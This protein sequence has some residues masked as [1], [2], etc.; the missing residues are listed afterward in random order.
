MPAAHQ[1][2]SPRRR[3]RQ[4]RRRP[5]PGLAA[6][7]LV[8]AAIAATLLARGGS[9]G[10]PATRTASARPKPKPL[11]LP[12]PIPGYLL[13]ADRG[14]NRILLV[15][16]RK[17]ILWRYPAPGHRPSYPF[18]FDDD[19]FFGP[20][21]RKIIS[22]QEDQQ[23]IQIVSFPAGRVLW[24]YGQPN[25][26]G[27]AAGYLN[28]PDDAYLLPHGVVTVAD[29]YNCRILY[30][31]RTKRIIRQLG[32]AGVCRHDPPHTL[33]AVNGGT[34]LPGGGILV[35]EI[36]GSW[37]DAFN[38]RGRLLWS[39][40]APVSY[41]SDPQ[42][43]GHGK[44]MLADYARPGHVLILTRTGRVLWRY[45]PPSGP[46]MLDHP[47]LAL[48][49]GHGLIAVNDDY[50]HRVVLL[51]V[52]RHRIV[53]QYGHTDQPGRKPGYLNIPDG[54]DLLPFHRALAVSTIRALLV[55]RH[56]LR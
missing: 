54:L 30:I 29:A 25:V 13:I 4:S 26:R 43:L 38:R 46:G 51:S 24:H 45:G 33:T 48:P 5:L 52:H 16:N 27:S 22:N 35:S 20:K 39:L 9:G 3:S 21:L 31:S 8:G 19:A 12:R 11:P 1:A 50:R 55:A 34:P 6:A 15:D 49:L 10:V 37:I 56:A 53:W 40:Q 2:R 28:T 32:T 23:T 18:H 47:S 17:R 7:L 44:I 36:S 14:N 41:P 42:W